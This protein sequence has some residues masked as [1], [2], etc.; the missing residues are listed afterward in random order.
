MGLLLMIS[1]TALAKE[2]F[3]QWLA[4]F[5]KIARADG[6]S[7]KTIRNALT[8]IKYKAKIVKADKYQPEHKQLFDAYNKKAMSHFRL[9]QGKK[10][11]AKNRKL[12]SRIESK[13]GVPKEFIVALWGTETAFG[14]YTGNKYI[15]EALATMAY[16]GRRRKFFTR[17]LLLALKIIDAGHIKAKNM[18]GSWAGAMGQCQFMPSSFL[19]YAVD[20]N[21]D[22]KR[23]IWHTRADVFASIANYLNRVGWK[24]SQK[25]IYEVRP[26]L[27][28]KTSLHKKW[29]SL[30]Y[31]RKQGFVRPNIGKLPAQNRKMKLILPDKKDNPYGRAFL[32]DSAFSNLMKWNR[33]TYFSISVMLLADAYK[34]KKPHK[35]PHFIPS[36]FRKPQVR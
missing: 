22:G 35:R 5:K 17:E 10:H 11:I 13:Y 15:P 28:F 24:K 12:L 31:W 18:K 33:S 29:R 32:V 23:D 27:G 1:N 19:A 21:K 30:K 8:G 14:G 4:D 16:E 36:I 26:P 3:S 34:D 6:V 2:S 9:T 20:Y 25:W 7:S